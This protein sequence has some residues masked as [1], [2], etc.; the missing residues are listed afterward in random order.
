MGARNNVSHGFVYKAVLSF[1]DKVCRLNFMPSL[2]VRSHWFVETDAIVTSL[3]AACILYTR[4]AGVVYF[5]TGAST[6]SI[7]VKL[8]KRAIRQPRPPPHALAGRRVKASFG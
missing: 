6:C 7:T 3:T 2:R 4:S 1:L 5:A 8:I